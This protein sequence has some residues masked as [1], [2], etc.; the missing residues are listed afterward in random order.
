MS[1]TDRDVVVIGAGIQ[2]AGVAYAAAAAGH[3]VL[4]LEK[5]ALAAGTS[6]KSSK[7]IHGGLRY[8]ES[9]QFGLVRESL[10]ERRIMLDIAPELVRLQPFFVPLYRTTRR[11]PW[12]LRLGL[13][14]Y[15]L[16]GGLG[17]DSRFGTVARRHWDRLDGLRT[18]DLRTVFRYHDAQTDD[19]ALTGAVVRTAQSLGAQL[20]L[21]ARFLGAQLRDHGVIVRY[22][23]EDREQECRARVLVSAAGAWAR[24]V[25]ERITP[26]VSIPTLELVQGT[27][28]IV[29]GELHGGLYYVESPRDGRAVFVMP[30]RGQMLVG[31][32]ETRFRGDPDQVQP[33]TPEKH[34]LVSVLRHYF[35]RHAALTVR[36]LAGAFAGLRVLPAGGGHAFHR[37][38][39]TLLGADRP[40]R[41]RFLGVY[42][43]KLTGWRATAEQALERIAGSLP[44]RRPR[45]DTRRHRLVVADENPR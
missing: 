2:G 43:G 27:H 10:R 26:A 14:L 3:S 13:S 36:D 30:W 19:A 21:P 39:E 16:L 40:Q 1:R 17:P 4:L 5:Q 37:S 38:R 25:G 28:V 15:A 6:S 35:P 33:L 7:L 18:R 11:H 41:P 44:A 9:G 22:A 23:H 12:Q 8:L 34:Y 24:E 32:T 31:T 20:A 42:G 45:V 29:P